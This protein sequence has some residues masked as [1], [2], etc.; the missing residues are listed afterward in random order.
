MGY[1]R[2]TYKMLTYTY[3][4]QYEQMLSFAYYL[5]S[6]QMNTVDYVELDVL[7]STI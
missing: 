7:V 2:T 3:K 6:Y 4:M 5:L 1:A